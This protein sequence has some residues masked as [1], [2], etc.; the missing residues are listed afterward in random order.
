[1]QSVHYLLMTGVAVLLCSP[2]MSRS[3]IRGRACADDETSSSAPV[4]SAFMISPL[5]CLP[6]VSALADRDI[7]LQS[8]SIFWTA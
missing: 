3:Y 7:P 1:M 5:P 6:T 8:T 4:N 2:E